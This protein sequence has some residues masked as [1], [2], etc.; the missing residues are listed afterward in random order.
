MRIGIYSI[1]Y[2]G[3]W[4]G[5]NAM[6]LKTL[7]R[8]AKGERWEGIE[9]DTERPHVA[10]MD[11]AANDRKELRELSREI[12]LPLG[13]GS[14]PTAICRARCPLPRGDDLLCKGMHRSRP[15]TS[16]LRSV[17]FSPLGAGS[18]FVAGWRR[19]TIPTG[20]IRTTTL[21]R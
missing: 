15:T 2:R 5:G 19:M 16:G 11:L 13:P 21:A 7:M 18:P 20:A 10:P 12:H 14:R 17:R 9:F 3:V 8:Y 1:T 6:D 4:Y